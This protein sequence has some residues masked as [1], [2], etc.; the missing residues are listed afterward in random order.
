M[1]KPDP[2]APLRTAL[3]GLSTDDPRYSDHV[4]AAIKSALKD[5]IPGRQQARNFDAIMAK[6]MKAAVRTLRR[7]AR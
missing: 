4:A 2:L 5:A 3:A 1:T 7:R 6:A